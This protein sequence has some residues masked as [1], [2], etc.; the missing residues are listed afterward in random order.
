MEELINAELEHGKYG[1]RMEP[2]LCIA[3]NPLYWGRGGRMGA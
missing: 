1:S 2:G 3:G